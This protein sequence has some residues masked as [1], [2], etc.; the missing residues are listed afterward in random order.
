MDWM[1]SFAWNVEGMISTLSE[2][3]DLIEYKNKHRKVLF[4][5]RSAKRILK[6]RKHYGF[7]HL[8]P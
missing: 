2:E 4:S 8:G 6:P 5:T 1:H 3:I 7:F